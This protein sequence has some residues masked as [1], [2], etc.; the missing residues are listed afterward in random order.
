ME[1]IYYSEAKFIEENGTIYLSK[2]QCKINAKNILTENDK[3]NIFDYN[4]LNTFLES[5]FLAKLALNDEPLLILGDTGYKT[6]LSEKLLTNKSSIINLNSKI[7]LN[8][9]LGSSIFFSKKEAGEFYLRNFLNLVI[10]DYEKDAKFDYFKKYINEKGKITDD[11]IKEALHSDFIKYEN[12]EKEKYK[13]K[14]SLKFFEKLINDINKNENIILEIIVLE[15]NPGLITYSYLGNENIILKNLSYLETSI[16]ERFNELFSESQIITLNEDIHKTFTDKDDKILKFNHIRIIATSY[17]E[18]ESKLSEAIASRFTML[19]VNS[20]NEQEESIMLKLYSKENHLNIKESVLKLLEDFFYD[21]KNTFNKKIYINQ[22][23]NILN[24]LSCINKAEKD[25]IKNAK[26]TLFILMKNC[27]NNK[28]ESC[29]EKLKEI[30]DEK[31]KEN[32]EGEIPFSQKEINGHECLL[33]KITNLPL[34][35]K[36]Q[37]ELINQ[38]KTIFFH[39]D[40]SELLDIIHFSI[41]CKTGLIIE[42][43][44]GQGKKTAIKYIA[45]LLG[46][47]LLNIYLNESTKIEDI[48]GN[49]VFD[50]DDNNELKMVN[51]KTDFIST[52]NKKNYAIIIFHNINKANSSIIEL[53]TDFYRKKQDIYITNLNKIS[54]QYDYNFF[55]SIF[56]SENNIKGKE[57]LPSSLVQNSIY[58]QMKNNAINYLN[59]IVKSRFILH[60]FNGE[61]KDFSN[62]FLSSYKFEKNEM[63]ESNESVLSLKELDKFIKLRQNTYKKLDINIILSFIFIFRY[64]DDE[65]RE[66]IKNVLKIKYDDIN[67]FIKLVSDAGHLYLEIKMNDKYSYLPFHEMK[68]NEEKNIN[69]EEINKNLVSLTG[70]QRYCLIFLSCCYIS[71]KPCILQGETSSDKTHLIHLFANMLG[72]KLKV[73]QKN[74]DSNVILINGQSKFE[75]LTVDEIE[76]LKTLTTELEELINDNNIM[77][78]QQN[79]ITV[80]KIGNLLEQANKCISRYSTHNNKIEEIKR[81]KKEILKIISPINRFRYNTSSFSESLEKGEWILIEQ[82]ESAPPEILERLF[83][84][85]QENPEIKIIQGTKEIIYKYKAQK[86]FEFDNN[87]NRDNNINEDDLNENKENIKYISPDFRIFFTYNPDKADIKKIR[88]C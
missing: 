52:L 30:L 3:N 60:E 81:I 9:L 70:P 32:K 23:L 41:F 64:S 21:Y 67:T 53:I 75:D 88:L 7:K 14:I 25:E 48:F 29:I 61:N 58:Y 45:S 79:D 42:G 83:P 55:I 82:I 56:T 54:P 68:D 63:K 38:N 37:N 4:K 12:L 65:I 44:D 10:D 34:E 22:K 78:K 39:K 1:D 72:K 46:Y 20:Y 80:E 85:T 57:Y 26:L 49:I 36:N 5:L 84:L 50:N 77:K 33:S 31:F 11:K 86:N 16:V 13:Y 73:Y 6:Y 87:L 18:Y 71:N 2:G 76:K 15:Y 8:H 24:I 69:I 62:A 59:Q 27:F 74:N 47:N 19:Q 51:V 66:K 17:P 40:F 28:K 35:I 43:M